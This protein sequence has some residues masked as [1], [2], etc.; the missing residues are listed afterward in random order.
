M[1]A[2]SY[3]RGHTIVYTGKWVY[4]DNGKPADDSRAC[5]RCARRPTAQGHDACLGHLPG[6]RSACCGHGVDEPIMRGT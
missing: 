1:T 2:T 3:V 5:P 4:A 6:V